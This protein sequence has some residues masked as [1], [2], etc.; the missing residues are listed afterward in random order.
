MKN[1]M[2]ICIC[3]LLLASVSCKKK[4]EDPEPVPYTTFTVNG[5][6]KNYSKYSKFSKDFCPTSTF[7]CRF[8]ATEIDQDTEQLDFGIPGNPIV[9]HVYQSGDNRFS[10]FYYSPIS[11][12]YELTETPFQVVFTLWQGQGGW[13]KGTFSGWMKSME[14]DSINIEN[15]YFQN[16]IWTMGT[17]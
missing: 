15:G 6:Q 10:C 12:R 13:A 8:S 4:K 9:G 3:A 11:G 1:F 16:K 7:C 17:K 14:G 5:I 2:L